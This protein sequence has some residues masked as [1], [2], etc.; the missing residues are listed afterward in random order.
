MKIW[1]KK[2]KKKTKL[3]IINY[4]GLFLGGFLIGYETMISE[5]VGMFT[6]ILSAANI[7]II[8]EKSR[9]TGE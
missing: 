9:W 7:G 6:L 5:F 1:G 8:K 4:L 2:M 3:N